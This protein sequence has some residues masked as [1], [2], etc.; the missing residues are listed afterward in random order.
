MRSQPSEQFKVYFLSFCLITVP[1]LLL[2]ALF[3][4]AEE[5]K[6]E[7]SISGTGQLMPEGSIRIVMAPIPGVVKKVYVKKND[8]IKAG[9]VLLEMDP[10]QSLLEGQNIQE[11]V[12][13]LKDEFVTLQAAFQGT[14]PSYL[15]ASLDQKAWLLQSQQ[16]FSS[17]LAQARHQIEESKHA[18][19]EIKAQIYHTE[20]LLASLQ[21]QQERYHN[22]Y[23]E[24]GI[25]LVEV[26]NFDDK[27][28]KVQGELASL[29]ETYKVRQAEL[30]KVSKKP[31]ELIGSYNQELLR[32]LAEHK[33]S[34]AQLNSNR[35]LNR[36]TQK[37]LFIRAPIDGI[38]HEQSIYGPGD[39]V[40]SPNEKLFSIVPANAKL[41]AE[42][43]VSNR[44]LSYIQ[45]DQKAALRLDAMPYQQFGR[46]YGT[47]MTI[48][49]STLLDP[50]GNPFYLVRILPDK[51][52][53]ADYTG[54]HHTLR[55]GMT[56][57]ADIITREKSILSFFTDPIQAQL[58]AAFRDPT[59]R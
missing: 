55:S 47:V 42:V 58:D 9:Q 10:E 5:S 6:I 7:E 1:I 23:K 38:I 32:E 13:F 46:L 36:F 51:S 35:D 18:V 21:E 34:I 16:A 50:S 48:S 39:I 53:L 54:K 11:Q 25:P 19:S 28:A 56:V 33:K 15:Q 8:K 27:V 45:L 29:K 52:W 22:L 24:D 37:R 3:Y 40:T 49:P 26:R 4:W 43:K 30:G 14:Q 41:V 57:M 20:N 12:A 59:T 2:A 31:S 17:E 44:D